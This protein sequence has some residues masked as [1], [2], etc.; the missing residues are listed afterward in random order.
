MSNVQKKT[1]PTFKNV[2]DEQQFWRK[3]DSTDYIDWNKA[4]IASFPNLKP[5]ATTIS[6]RL[7]VALLDEIKIIAH[8]DDIPYQSLIKMILAQ[9]VLSIRQRA[10]C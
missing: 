1:I 7:P 4:K 8:K 6:L 10:C 9:K 2:N 5:S 3:N